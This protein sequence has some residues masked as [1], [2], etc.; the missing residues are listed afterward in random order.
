MQTFAL[1]SEMEKI[2]FT[3]YIMS[4]AFRQGFVVCFWRFT[5]NNFSEKSSYAVLCSLQAALQPSK[6]YDLALDTE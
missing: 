5:S 3:R 2:I 6:A 1:K 4:E